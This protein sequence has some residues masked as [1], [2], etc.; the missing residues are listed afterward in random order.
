MVIPMC[1]PIAPHLEKYPASPAIPLYPPS[2]PHLA[3]I[4][5]LRHLGKF[6]ADPGDLGKGNDL[7]RSLECGQCE[8]TKG[9]TFRAP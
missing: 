4:Q 8:I 5:L 6:V 2:P 1:P 7:L 3:D 9:L